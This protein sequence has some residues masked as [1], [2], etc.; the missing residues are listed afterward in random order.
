MIRAAAPVVAAAPV[1]AGVAAPPLPTLSPRS[2]APPRPATATTV[3]AAPPRPADD[4]LPVTAEPASAGV[5]HAAPPRGVEDL[6]PVVPVE[7][8]GSAPASVARRLPPVDRKLLMIGAGIVLLIA[9]LAF[10][11]AKTR[12]DVKSAINAPAQQVHDAERIAARAQLQT[13][14]EAAQSAYVDSGTYSTVTPATLR[15]AE[16]SIVWLAGNQEAEPRQVSVQVV[17]AQS[18]VLVTALPDGSCVGLY[19]S[20]AGTVSVD[21]APPCMAT[22]YTPG[23][24]PLGTDDSAT[25]GQPG[26]PNIPSLPTDP[27]ADPDLAG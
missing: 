21:V 5:P 1:R 2:A 25:G 11:W 6:L 10:V 7:P 12:D 15:A 17:D 18:I 3:A 14:A 8:A 4:L 22:S 16:P 20:P 24:A 27:G 9:A 23:G 19:Q 26:I 13:A